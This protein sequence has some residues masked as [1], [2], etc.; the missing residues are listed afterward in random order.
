[1]KTIRFRISI[2]LC[3][4][5]LC[6]LVAALAACVQT[7]ALSLQIEG[8]AYRGA[9][10]QIVA[11][12]TLGEDNPC[13]FSVTQG[14][15]Y[16]YWTPEGKLRIATDAPVGQAITVRVSAGDRYCD[17]TVSVQHTP[18][19]S[20]V[21]DPV[22]AQAA[23]ATLRLQ[24]T[25]FPAY[26]DD[27]AVQFSLSRGQTVAHL[28]GNILTISPTADCADTI[29]VYATAGGVQSAPITIA[30]ATVQPTSFSFAMAQTTLQRGQSVHCA[31]QVQPQEAQAT[32]TYCLLGD[33]AILNFV[34]LQQDVITIAADAPEGT[35]VLQATVG[36]LTQTLPLTIA[37]TPVTR[38]TLM[39]NLSGDVVYYQD[40]IQLTT[41]VYPADATYPDVA[42]TIVQGDDCL[43]ATDDG[44]YIVTGR[45]IGR[46]IQFCATADGMSTYLTL[47]TVQVPV[48][49]LEIIAQGSLSVT[50]GE[51]RQLV[52]SYT[53]LNA[54]Y[55]PTLSLIEGQDLAHLVDGV[56]YFDALGSGN[57]PVTVQAT[58][59]D[60]TATV[61]FHVAP[62][63]V[64]SV[65]ISTQDPVQGLV[66]GDIVHIDAVVSP[67]NASYP[68]LTYSLLSGDWL[69]H[70][71]GNVFTVSDQ[72]TVGE[73]TLQ[74]T[75][76]DGVQS[77]VLTLQIAGD[78]RTFTPTDWSV[79]DNN[80]A[81]LAGCGSVCLDLT[82]LPY[83]AGDTLLLIDDTVQY[84]HVIG[85]YDGTTDSCFTDLYFYFLTQHNIEVCFSQLG[86]R[87]TLGFADP[88]VDFNTQA[89]V[90]LQLQGD[91]YIAAGSPYA[92][93]ANE[94]SVHGS[95]ATDATLC[96]GMHGFWG[97]DGG[98]AICG[99]RITFTG[100]GNLSLTGGNGASGTD[101]RHG[102]DSDNPAYPAGNGGDGGYGGN[103]GLALDV[104]SVSYEFDGT[105]SLI[106]GNAGTGGLAGLGGLGAT[107]G[108]DGLRGADGA[109]G[110]AVRSVEGATYLSG[111]VTETT[112][113]VRAYNV[114]RPFTTPAQAAALLS[115]HYK[116]TILY[117]QDLYNPYGT[118]L[119]RYEMTQQTNA[120]QLILQLHGLDL[121]LSVLGR[122]LFVEL[123]ETAPITFYLANS[124][125]YKTLTST[126]IIYGLTDT[127]NRVWF[128]T[129][130]PRKRDTFYSTYYNIM[131]HEMLHLLT[132][133]MGKLAD[134]PMGQSGGLAQY[135]LGHRYTQD[136]RNV[137]D[138][139]AGYT[140]ANSAFLTRY[141]QKDFNE[142]ISDNLSLL[143]LLPHAAPYTRADMPLAQKATYITACYAAYYRG[144]VTWRPPRWMRFVS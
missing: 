129:F 34:T 126:G 56:L 40:T 113:A 72:A 142:D 134:N 73:V 103:G 31:V 125:T 105:L 65:T 30:V 44:G 25:V 141:S 128:A 107:N 138:P 62:I 144:I 54:G 11:T 43:Q 84:L 42:I 111:T 85:R 109:I 29:E 27:N 41:R 88:V 89:N 47:H 23:G 59:G 14:T 20:I 82:R 63:P 137:Y 38:V 36:G 49:T 19:Q 108:T 51:T 45:E 48:Q 68:A 94:L 80:A 2:L 119:S 53:P 74:A 26:A 64:T 76:G 131:I 39:A 115:K 75:S 35:F 71:D 102:V 79:L 143:C 93:Y 13:R 77:N 120:Q 87:S 69:G 104:Y 130:T 6:A 118:G 16:A 9:E 127:S 112:G 123:S 52:V 90:Y 139:A 3:A 15:E 8:V 33:D 106:G 97:Q 132:F 18:V 24:C 100:S 140:A 98:T 83:A 66:A 61:T 7:P 96:H 12:T 4:I 32:A 92:T 95:D 116:V 78:M 28:D 17:Q 58:C 22:P 81:Y 57:D 37:K 99:Y 110:Q 60:K 121:A 67:Q 124:I 133:G 1:M 122:N 70:L 91:N 10:L 21:I 114:T 50:V 46:T 101:G 136:G 5:L 86:I 55:T 135:N 117:G